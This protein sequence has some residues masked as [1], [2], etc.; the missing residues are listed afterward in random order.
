MGLTFTASHATEIVIP[1]GNLIIRY[2]GQYFTVPDG[3]RVIKARLDVRPTEVSY[4]GVTPGSQ[5][6][7]KIKSLQT[8]EGSVTYSLVCMQHLDDVWDST[9][10]AIDEPTKEYYMLEWSPE[11]NKQTPTITDY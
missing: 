7:F 3:V 10:I 9:R 5:H 1:T 4:V 2:D 8:T 11:I 6:T